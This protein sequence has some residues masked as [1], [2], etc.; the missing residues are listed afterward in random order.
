MTH[1]RSE[2][3]TRTWGFSAWKI[4]VTFLDK[5]PS[6]QLS[7]QTHPNRTAVVLRDQRSR[8]FRSGCA[9]H[10]PIHRLSHSL[11]QL[12]LHSS[13]CL[14]WSIAE[15]CSFM[16]ELFFYEWEAPA[17]SPPTTLSL[18]DMN[19]WMEQQRE[20]DRQP[21]RLSSPSLR[22]KLP[23]NHRRAGWLMLY[24]HSRAHTVKHY[25]RANSVGEPHLSP[26]TSLAP[27]WKCVT[28]EVFHGQVP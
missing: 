20:I 25:S 1:Q 4:G 11:P 16:N 27:L 14:L 2:S 7:I 18:C 3:C 26:P 15:Q 28:N 8:L 6:L 5:L 12:H 23:S 9:R 24:T 21:P 13:C 10:R 22:F 19:V 17:H